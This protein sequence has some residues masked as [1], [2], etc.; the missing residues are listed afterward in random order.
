MC[1]YHASPPGSTER[2]QIFVFDLGHGTTIGGTDM[3]GTG[4]R[5][6]QLR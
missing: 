4:H 3:D 2:S 1:K 5:H 6:Q